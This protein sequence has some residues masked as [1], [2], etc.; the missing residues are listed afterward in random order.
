MACL[1]ADYQENHEQLIP[2]LHLNN[3]LCFVRAAH[4]W[5][6]CAFYKVVQP[7]LPGSRLTRE[8]KVF[9]AHLHKTSTFNPDGP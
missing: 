8:N 6:R 1:I 3:V 9:G 2:Y 5:V 4:V 7:W